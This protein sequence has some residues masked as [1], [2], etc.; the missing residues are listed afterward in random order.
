MQYIILMFL[1]IS[2]SSYAQDSDV[3]FTVSKKPA[4]VS[5]SPSID[6][7]Y[8]CMA[9]R[10]V[11]RGL[12]VKDIDSISF[13]QAKVKLDDVLHISNASMYD[14]VLKLYAHK[15][16]VMTEVFS[17]R[18][19]VTYCA[20]KPLPAKRGRKKPI[21]QSLSTQAQKRDRRRTP[22]SLN[23]TTTNRQW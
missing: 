5:I 11:L 20:D 19:V 14:T 2:F 22:N 23:T 18:F 21:V 17:K 13:G 4:V 12:D 16:G 6:T 3:V 8:N 10:F 9:Y 7:L 1:L 15:Q